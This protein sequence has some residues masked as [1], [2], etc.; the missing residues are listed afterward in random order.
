MFFLVQNICTNK[1]KHYYKGPLNGTIHVAAGGAG[2]SLSPFTTIQTHWSIFRDLDYG[3]VKLTAFDHSNLLFEYKKSRDGNVYDS[4]R[5]SR[6]YRDILACAV[7]SCP[8]STL[9]S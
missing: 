4:F 6:D 3:F 9:A 2:A 1:E 5:I 8:S 7:D